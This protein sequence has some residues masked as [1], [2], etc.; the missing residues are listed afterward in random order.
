[1]KST[2]LVVATLMAAPET[3]EAFATL[4]SISRPLPWTARPLAPLHSSRITPLRSS[5]DAGPEVDVLAEEEDPEVA[6]LLA[7]A[8]RLRAE[9]AALESD[10]LAKQAEV[11]QR[12]F[13]KFDTNLDG[14]ISFDELK[15][16]LERELKME[17]SEK[18]VASLM[19]TFDTS[20]DGALQLDEFKTIEQFRSMLDNL[21]IEEIQMA[22]EAAAK[23]KAAEIEAKMM[24]ARA[25][26]LNDSE[27]TQS[28]KIVSILPYLFPLM[29]GIQYG[30]FILQNG[31]NN[32]LVGAVALLYTIYR[33]IPFS[34]FVAFFA[35]NFLAS[36]TQINR[37]VRFNMQQ[38]IFIDIAL[39]FP[40]L[41]FGLGQSLLPALGVQ[42]PPALLE[43]PSD[44]VFVTL[45]VTL[46]Y[47]AISSLTGNEPNM[48][49]LISK[50]VE[51]RMP[52]TEWF[53]AEGRFVPKDMRQPKD[54]EDKDKKD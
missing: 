24:E 4:P 26:L 52:T 6:Q 47:C 36:N 53:D 34:G 20:G 29:D 44:V 42:V 7:Q 31:D 45:L 32:P 9:A 8:S 16:G 50:S 48:L 19:K 38:A 5:P 21:G 11:T 30:R 1:M 10:R 2:C 27:P 51:D 14:E 35:L 23:V 18:R 41:L 54:D 37:L 49:P 33:S 40:G 15:T 39:F 46:A 28:D 17:L 22:K 3:S 13:T 12:I 25:A 43:L